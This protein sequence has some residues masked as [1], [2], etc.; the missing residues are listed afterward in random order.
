MYRLDI[1]RP[2]PFF[3]YDHEKQQKRRFIR[4]IRP[5]R[6]T[7]RTAPIHILKRWNK[8]NKYLVEHQIGF[9]FWHHP[10]ASRENFLH[11][12][13]IEHYEIFTE[14]ISIALYHDVYWP[15]HQLAA[16]KRARAEDKALRKWNKKEEECIRKGKKHYSGWD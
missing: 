16:I 12:N 3:L 8:I 5:I 10:F 15:P 14:G 7:K 4:R 13:E 6:G 11:I 1:P 9:E 2:H